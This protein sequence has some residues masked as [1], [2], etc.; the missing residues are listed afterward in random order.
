MSV[1]IINTQLFRT[2]ESDRARPWA[3]MTWTTTEGERCIGH[4]DTRKGAVAR[5]RRYRTA[6]LHQATQ[7][8]QGWSLQ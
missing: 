8:N 2:A 7:T 4:Y 3:V 5:A 6:L 1:T